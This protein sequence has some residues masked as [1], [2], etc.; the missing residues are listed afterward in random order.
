MEKNCQKICKKNEFEIKTVKAIDSLDEK[1]IIEPSIIFIDPP[2]KKENIS[3]ILLKLLKNKIKSK[4]T[5]IIIETSKEEK[6][7]IPEGLTLFKEKVYGRTKIL[8]L[9]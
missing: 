7:V 8:F 2:Y 5:F 9:N 4:K 6:I 1:F 3:L